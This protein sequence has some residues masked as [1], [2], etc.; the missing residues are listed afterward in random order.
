MNQEL[1]KADYDMIIEKMRRKH[2]KYRGLQK[3][4]LRS[5]KKCKDLA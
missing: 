1:T 4:A 2:S 5:V 3:P